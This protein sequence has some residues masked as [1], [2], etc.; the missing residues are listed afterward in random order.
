MNYLFTPLKP[1]LH[2]L[3]KNVCFMNVQGLD[4]MINNNCDWCS[5][6][7]GIL[8][9]AKQNIIKKLKH[10]YRNGQIGSDI[11]QKKNKKLLEK[12]NRQALKD[13][14]EFLLPAHC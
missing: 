3:D 5:I 10:V 13:W 4:Y 6:C 12:S 1:S 14:K 9:T 8:E 7:N 11:L 2:N